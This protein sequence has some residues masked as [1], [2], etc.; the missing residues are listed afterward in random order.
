METFWIS[1]G[2]LS[3]LPFVMTKHL[4]NEQAIALHANCMIMINKA[5]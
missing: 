5:S 1:T 2:T 3:T 4:W